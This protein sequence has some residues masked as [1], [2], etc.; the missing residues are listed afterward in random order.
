[1]EEP[2][3]LD[4]LKS[5]LRLRGGQKIIIPPET[6][7]EGEEVNGISPTTG[8]VRT[9]TEE[10]LQ[11]P[12]IIQKFPVEELQVAKADELLSKEVEIPSPW[13]WRA[14]IALFLALFAQL[15][16]EPPD[17]G[18]FPGLIFYG[19]AALML[20]WSVLKNEFGIAPLPHEETK[21]PS[22]QTHKA[23]LAL[24]GLMMV[25]AFLMFSNNTFTLLN[26]ILWV[27]TL[28]YLLYAL[29]L[30]QKRQTS[31]PS[32]RESLAA[33]WRKPTIHLV[34]TPWTMV[35]LAALALAIFFRFYR[36]N[37]VPGEMFSDHAEKLLDVSD[38]LNG[39]FSIFF[40]RN[41]G[42]EADQMYWSAL[43][44]IVFNTGVS[45]ITLK[46]GTTLFG[47]FTLPFIYLLGKEIANRWVGLIAFVLTAIGYWPNLISRIGLRFPLY[48]LFVA[49]MLYFLIRGLCTSNRNDFV[50]SGL[51]LGL[52]LQ[53]YSPYR[54]VPFVVVIAIAIYLVHPQSKGKRKETIWALIALALV[55]LVIFLPLMRYMF[56]N[57]AMFN[58]R[59]MTRLGTAERP[60]PGPAGLIFMSNLWKAWVMFFWDNGNIWVHSVVGRPALDVVTAAL[61][62]LGSLLLLIRY[63]RNH[64]WLDLFMLLSVPLFLMP[65]IL[66]LAFPDENPSLNRTSGAIIP[67]FMIASIALEGILAGLVKRVKSRRMGIGV[68]SVLVLFLFTWSASQ[69]FD[70]VFHQ[71]DKQFMAGA[72][73]TDEMGKIIR[74]FA[75]SIG[76][77]DSAYVV[78]YPYWV[79]TR[80]VGINAGFPV[81]DYALWPENF[82]DTLAEPHAKLFLVKNEDQKDLDALVALYPQSTYWLYHS[83]LEGKEFWILLVPPQPGEKQQG[84][85][86]NFLSLAGR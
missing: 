65:S 58:Y 80:L 8:P 82:K 55:S 63:I 61:Y 18:L 83:K 86:A 1:M 36:L 71:F 10:S 14:V 48:P 84:S 13:P 20:L 47:L 3:V 60:L 68:A 77:E 31:R 15:G 24:S 12:E 34:I 4:Y 62:F 5:L 11:E 52:G 78:P 42:R 51:A 37:Q 67:V 17:R 19:L 22:L 66:S 27:I 33:W 59:T 44:S 39:K 7:V 35:L 85:L 26:V 81:K 79:D 43:L 9:G 49:P 23:A 64:H 40:P 28:A 41:T 69:N 50:L 32:L 75:D 76:T 46:L 38:I 70:L 25:L 16:F 54:I 21:P 57:M 2:S 73:N 72:W 53:G 29:W 30:P 74:A 6:P 45:F 56:D